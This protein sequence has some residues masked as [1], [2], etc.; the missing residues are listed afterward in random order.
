[1]SITWQLIISCKSLFSSQNPPLKDR[2]TH[3]SLYPMGTDI[4]SYRVRM[5][6]TGTWGCFWKA[7]KSRETTQISNFWY[8][9]DS[10]IQNFTQHQASSLFWMCSNVI[11][12]NH[13]LW[14]MS[15]D[16]IGVKD[17]KSSILTS[18]KWFTLR[19]ISILCSPKVTKKN[20][21]ILFIDLGPL[22]QLS[23]RQGMGP[24]GGLEVKYLFY[25]ICFLV[26]L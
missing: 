18:S 19:K 14:C 25:F 9:F 3:N 15:F 5:A 1:M 11:L 17:V 7:K 4:A 24:P 20:N 22:P 26:P 8:S 21:K 6:A 13:V 12:Y 16:N 2:I 23:K 10:E